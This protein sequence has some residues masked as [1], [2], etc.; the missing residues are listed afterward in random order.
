MSGLR[1]LRA[2]AGRWR[3]EA[4]QAAVEYGVLTW[5]MLVGLAFGGYPMFIGLLHAVQIYFDSFFLV[6]RL[7]IP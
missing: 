1:A 7:P 6:L 5:A 3:E 2:L 4:G